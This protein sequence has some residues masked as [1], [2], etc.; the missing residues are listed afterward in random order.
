[1]Q[2]GRAG[3]A[4]LNMDGDQIIESE[5]KKHMA[6]VRLDN[7]LEYECA[8]E[9]KIELETLKANKTKE[10]AKFDALQGKYDAMKVKVDKLEKDLAI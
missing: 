10:K 8:E 4:R 3:N 6:K 5:D 2:K 9:V 7:G 1:M